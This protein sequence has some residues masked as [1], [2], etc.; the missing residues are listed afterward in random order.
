MSLPR[1]CHRVTKLEYQEC[2]RWRKRVA[3][4]TP[5]EVAE[6]WASLANKYG[7]AFIEEIQ[8]CLD[9]AGAEDIDALLAD[10]TTFPKRFQEYFETWQRNCDEAHSH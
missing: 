7:R 9:S 2:E 10:S 3:Q 5:E 1:L 4:M 8:Q 6:A